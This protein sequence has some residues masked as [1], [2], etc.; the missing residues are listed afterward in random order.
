M[1]LIITHVQFLGGGHHSYVLIV[2]TR[3]ISE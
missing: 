1:A 3:S 2:N